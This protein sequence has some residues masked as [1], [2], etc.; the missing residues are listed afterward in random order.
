MKTT[1][2]RHLRPLFAA[3]LTGALTGCALTPEYIRPA[4]PVPQEW[5][6][7]TPTAPL[8]QASPEWESFVVDP[9]LS[10]LVS[11]ALANN[12]DLR[13]TL[14]NVEAA[15]AQYRIQRADRLPSVSAEAN[16]TRQRVPGD[17]S[18]TGRA[19][20]QATY[21]AGFGL[22][23][24]E[25]DL[26]G[27]VQSLSDAAMQTFFATEEAARG[28]RL[29]LVAEVVQA[30]ISRDSAQRRLE[31][32]R[33]TLEARERSLYLTEQR[34]RNGTAGALDHQEAVSLTEQARADLER[35]QRELA[36]TDNALRLLAGD[37]RI[38]TT[39]P[40]RPAEA[41]LLVREV[42]PGLP[43][44]L[45]ARRPDILQ[46]EHELKARHAD[47]GAAR[48]AFFPRVT[49]S[50]FL[51]SSSAE[52]S[53]LFS[54]GQGAWSFAPQL[55]VP[56]FDAGR[57]RANLSLAEVRKDIAVAN[58]ESR[59]QTAFMEVADALAATDTLRREEAARRNLAQSSAETLRLSE[60]RYRAGMD[61]HLRY[62][63]A[64]RS[65]YANQ[66]TLIE[67]AAERQT[68][69]VTLFRTL[70]GAW[71]AS[72]NVRSPLVGIGRW[73]RASD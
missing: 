40:L 54:G 44:D 42:V 49:L 21:Q 46:A 11:T 50:G 48:A 15:R 53:Q 5:P 25:L 68:A 41:P 69:L 67:V 9:H 3:L 45:I 63:D 59:I 6:A 1:R 60:A 73:D 4:A 51:G 39:L 10:A 57:N 2:S 22:A 61:S 28:A 34:R 66:A 8:S 65:R 30:Y 18:A 70:G 16:G 24:F 32:T 71:S 35:V 43:A 29:S 33:Q 20:T 17:L 19:N 36:Q 23:S 55:T 27:R 62:L 31:L 12:R 72:D 7:S 26:F 47:I 37:E 14:L 52:L 64:Q 58:Y 13:Q 56:L 38:L